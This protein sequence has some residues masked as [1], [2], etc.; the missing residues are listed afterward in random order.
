MWKLE[1]LTENSV[2]QSL[3][4]PNLDGYPFDVT[5]TA[6]YELNDKGMT[7]TVSARND[8]DEPAPWA[9]G[10]HPWVANGKNGETSEQRDADSAACRLK[11]DADTHVTVD[12]GLVPN[13]TEPVDGTKFDL[14]DD[15]VL[16]GRAFDDAWV[17]VHRAD[18]GTTT[19]VFTRPDGMEI[20]LV[21]DET[22]NAWQCY[23][24]TGAP[25]DQHPNG[26][27]VEPM[28]AP[29]NAFRSGD[30]LTVIEPGKSVTTVVRYEVTVK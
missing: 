17:D 3:R 10:L 16:D 23:T 2:T 30:H 6:T 12:A 29:A 19:T 24:A 11:I 1:S 13:G 7:V 26:I 27:A 22:I 18:D 20:K 14:R 28:T 5:V 21:G 9:L 15:P 8:G 25:F 4:F